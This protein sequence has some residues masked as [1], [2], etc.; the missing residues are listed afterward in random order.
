MVTGIKKRKKIVDPG[1]FYALPEKNIVFGVDLSTAK[2]IAW[3]VAINERIIQTGIEESISKIFRH[4]PE[5]CRI[6]ITE[7][8]FVKKNRAVALELAQAAGMLKMLCE[9]NDIE[10]RQVLGIVWQAPIKKGFG[11]NGKPAGMN[12]REW[13]KYRYKRFRFYIHSFLTNGLKN[14]DFSNDQVA[15]ACL[16]LHGS[17]EL[18]RF[19]LIGELL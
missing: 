13:E 10:F 7:K 6:V 1:A 12:D 8:M 19:R 11:L 17:R 2:G 9:E 3:A 18:R 5:G 4:V 16:A 15:A 14:K